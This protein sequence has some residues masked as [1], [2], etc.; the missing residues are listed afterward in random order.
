MEDKVTFEQGFHFHGKNFQRIR[1]MV[2][3]AE[4]NLIPKRLGTRLGRGGG[5]G[6][7]DTLYYT[8]GG[9]CLAG[10]SNDIVTAE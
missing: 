5:G 8:A 9:N 10:H 7:G 6:G 2:M 3:S 1:A 4:D